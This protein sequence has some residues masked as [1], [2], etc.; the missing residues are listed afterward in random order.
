MKHLLLFLLIYFTINLVSPLDKNISNP[1]VELIKSV[2]VYFVFLLL[3]IL[4]SYS[5]ILV[6]VLFA[7][8]VFATN[9]HFYYK[10]SVVD[11]KKFKYIEDFLYIIEICLLLGIFIIIII[12]GFRKN[13]GKKI[14]KHFIKLEKCV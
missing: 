10:D 14:M 9:A 1:V 4:D 11:K 6:L 12:N 13:T 5:I 3:N 7:I 8:L 2:G